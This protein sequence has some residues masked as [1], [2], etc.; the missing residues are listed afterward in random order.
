VRRIYLLDRNDPTQNYA[1][2]PGF[3]LTAANRSWRIYRRCN[4]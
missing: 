1:V 2:P 4:A 3:T